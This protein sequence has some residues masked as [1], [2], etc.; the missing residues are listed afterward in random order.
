[1]AHRRGLLP[2]QELI[3]AR[4]IEDVTK[5]LEQ[6][7]SSIP[8]G[9]GTGGNEFFNLFP[10]THGIYMQVHLQDGKLLSMNLV[11]AEGLELKDH[12]PHSAKH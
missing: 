5:A 8:T 7:K 4:I 2:H 10:E 11:T 6:L 12:P 9:S 1:M 3:F